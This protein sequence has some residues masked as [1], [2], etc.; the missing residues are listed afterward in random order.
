MPFRSRNS[1]NCHRFTTKLDSAEVKAAANVA[2]ISTFRLPY[3]SLTNPHTF[4]VII[5]PATRNLK[6]ILQDWDYISHPIPYIHTTVPNTAHDAIL[7]FRCD[8]QV[9]LSH[10][11]SITNDHCL[12][13]YARHENARYEYEAVMKFAELLTIYF[14]VT[15]HSIEEKNIST[16]LFRSRL[17]RTIPRT[18]LCETFPRFHRLYSPSCLV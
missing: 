15:L 11:Q 6:K 9:A 2:N 7:L 4:D 16:H 8:V 12:P 18:F 17:L 5:I 3:V 10:R 1:T 14:S 13:E